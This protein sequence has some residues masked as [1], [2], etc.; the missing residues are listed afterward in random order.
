MI[1]NLDYYLIQKILGFFQKTNIINYNFT[2]DYFKKEYIFF[3]SRYI[4]KI[5]TDIKSLINLSMVSKNY[6]K[7]INNS[8]IGKLLLTLYHISQKNNNNLKLYHMKHISYCKLINCNDIYHYINHDIKNINVKKLSMAKNK[9]KN[10]IFY[11]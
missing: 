11:K 6:Y 5:S 3:I 1:L 7:F 4:P 9:T 10:K 8:D 2:D